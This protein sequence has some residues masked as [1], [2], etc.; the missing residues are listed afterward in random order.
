M[1]HE[2]NTWS[3]ALQQE[4]RD[5]IGE[6]RIGPDGRLHFKS[7]GKGSAFMTAQNLACGKLLLANKENDQVF[8]YA[9]VDELLAAGWAVD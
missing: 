1:N 7:R 2:I 6:M 9:D 8:E 3:E 4:T 5:A